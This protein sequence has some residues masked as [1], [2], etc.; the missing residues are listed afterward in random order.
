M[1][2]I[3]YGLA[4]EEGSVLAFSVVMLTLMIFLVSIISITTVNRIAVARSVSENSRETSEV[5]NIN[6]N[7]DKAIQSIVLQ[8]DELTRYYL[9]QGYYEKDNILEFNSGAKP[10]FDASLRKLIDDSFQ[11]SVKLV[12]QARG[13]AGVEEI[14]DLL[15]ARM[16]TLRTGGTALTVDGG[17]KLDSFLTK[18]D[19]L[20]REEPIYQSGAGGNRFDVT[21]D[22]TFTNS[23]VSATYDNLRT[24]RDAV[25]AGNINASSYLTLSVDA[26]FNLPESGNQVTADI[27]VLFTFP[28]Y[29]YT[30]GPDVTS[31]NDSET[32]YNNV[33]HY[34]VNVLEY[35]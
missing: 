16:L 33:I 30:T 29:S 31:P 17:G 25:A 8:T 13:S 35:Q 14:A 10:G 20:I 26:L 9:V 18:V 6:A 34:T 7:L 28:E 22:P 4:N 1:K 21:T 23:S 27:Q 32:L 11:A 19:A 2:R 5:E 12:Y 3:K 15:F 24:K